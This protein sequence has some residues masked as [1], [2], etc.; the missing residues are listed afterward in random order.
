MEV[1]LQ[2][3]HLINRWFD[4]E[5]ILTSRLFSFCSTVHLGGIGVV[6]KPD[7][8]QLRF[9]CEKNKN[10][11]SHCRNEA[12]EELL[13]TILFLGRVICC[14]RRLLSW[15]HEKKKSSLIHHKKK[16]KFLSRFGSVCFLY[17]CLK[18]A[19]FA[20]WN[21]RLLPTTYY[22]KKVCYQMC[23]WKNTCK[24]FILPPQ[25]ITNITT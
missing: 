19:Y 14:S 3:Q 1:K 22:K 8:P 12:L 17:F 6:V 18:I 23:L 7:I 24:N 11:P 21:W 15:S 13:P 20:L 10:Q 5:T 9:T 2:S 16:P 4:L 25:S